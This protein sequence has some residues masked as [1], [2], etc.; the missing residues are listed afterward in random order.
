MSMM[1]KIKEGRVKLGRRHSKLLN[2]ICFLFFVALS[3]LSCYHGRLDFVLAWFWMIGLWLWWDTC[4]FV[5]VIIMNLW[6]SS[7]SRL[8]IICYIYEHPRHVVL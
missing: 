3:S 6:W 2:V 5:L 8:I 7:G 1:N 4:P